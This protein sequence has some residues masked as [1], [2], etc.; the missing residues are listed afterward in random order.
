MSRWVVISLSVFA[1]VLVGL[2]VLLYVTRTPVDD[3][4]RLVSEGSIT[5]LRQPLRPARSD[6]PRVLVIAIDGVG[7]SEFRSAIRERRLPHI[8]RFL[9][10]EDPSTTVWRNAYVPRGTLSILPSTTYAAWTAVFTG[11]PVARSGISGNEWFDRETMSFVA[12]APVSVS[13]YGHA[14][15]VYA[16]GLMND[17]VEVPTLFERADVR[18]YASLIPQHRG[19]DLLIRPHPGLVGDIVAGVAAGI[20]EDDESEPDTYSA[21]DRQ[22][23]R[24]TIEAIETYGLAD[25][26]VVYFPGIDLY[27]HVAEPALPEQID[28]LEDVIDPLFADIIAVYDSLGALDDTYVI[29]VSDHGHTPS[30]ETDRNALGT[31]VDGEWPAVVE[32]AGFRVRPFELETDDHAYQA[33][34]AYQGAFAYLYLADRSTCLDEYET[35]AWAQPARFEEDILAA[36][37]AIDRTNRE[38]ALLPELRATL[39]LI[40]AR[41]PRGTAAAAP[42]Q[43]WDGTRLVPVADYL[44]ENPRPD[45]IDL[46]RRLDALASGP[47]GHRA[48]DI[49]LLSRYRF[50]DP[51]EERFYFSRKYRSWHGS[52]SAQDSEILWVLARAGT[53]GA[54]LRDLAHEAVGEKP[55]QL[56]VTPLVLHLLEAAP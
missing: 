20:Q 31:G 13:G 12:P 47:Y 1:V 33:V 5:E 37:T 17:W 42:F 28:Y 10:A 7:D 16:D 32:A 46:E 2:G 39:D 53:S 8:A 43:I 22:S 25:L 52:P 23:V 34:F 29:F 48:G 50:E 38:G 9:G 41:E 18:S 11:E 54:H 27:T 56:D 19:A 24:K 15:A 35:C 40:L 26:T 4:A 6:A 49:L 14:L 45:L 21:L 55:G 3:L 51:I 30:L 36:V 44:A